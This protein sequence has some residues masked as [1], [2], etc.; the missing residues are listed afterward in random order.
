[1][2]SALELEP[3]NS[4]PSIDESSDRRSRLTA[5]PPVIELVAGESSFRPARL[6]IRKYD[7]GKGDVPGR[8]DNKLSPA[9]FAIDSDAFSRAT[10]T[11][12]MHS[13]PTSYEN[14]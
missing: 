13:T 14:S 2:I 9:E 5:V 4:T 3:Y 7:K 8:P 11:A 12:T 6:L 10:L 1:M